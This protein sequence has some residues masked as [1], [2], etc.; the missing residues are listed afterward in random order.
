MEITP[1]TPIALVFEK[2]R[3]AR[4]RGPLGRIPAEERVCCRCRRRLSASPGVGLSIRRDAR[5]RPTITCD[6][7][8]NRGTSGRSTVTLEEEFFQL[9]QRALRLRYQQL[10]RRHGR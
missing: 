9:K 7:C 4:E 3:T 2:P 6:R 1:H 5:G 8:R 10:Q